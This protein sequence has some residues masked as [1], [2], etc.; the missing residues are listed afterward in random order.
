METPTSEQDREQRRAARAE[1][2]Q[3]KATRTAELLRLRREGRT[4]QEIGDAFGIT[5]QAA[6][7]A[8]LEALKALPSMEV[9]QHRAEQAERLDD[10]LRRC[11][12]VLGRKHLTVSQGR[13]VRIGE[14]ALDDEGQPYID[15]GHGEPLEDDDVVLRTLEQIR[16]IEA[17]RRVLF[18]LNVVVKQELNTTVTTYQVQLG[19]G[20]VEALT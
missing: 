20:A 5:R 10:L 12:E 7:K 14:P 15:D 19:D 18:G 9:D 11:Y 17:D 2:E 1:R 6:H 13:V 16:K 3:A 4:F 8:Y